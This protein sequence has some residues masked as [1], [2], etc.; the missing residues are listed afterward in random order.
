MTT[1][2]K[3]LFNF[4][5][6]ARKRGFSDRQIKIALAEKNYPEKIFE[7]AFDSFNP[8]FNSKNQ[9]SIFLSDD[10]LKEL[11]KRAKKN[12]FNL[13]EQI[14]DVL[15]RSCARRTKNISQSDKID[16]FLLS[17]FSRSPRGRKRKSK[18]P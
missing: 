12:M 6:E 7:K 18:N 5:K 8:K 3:Q 17:C 9:V 16:D 10:I 15:R 2:E 11:E 13:E 4:I 14:E 1:H